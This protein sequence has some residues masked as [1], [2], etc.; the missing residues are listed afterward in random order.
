MTGVRSS[1]KLEAACRDQIPYL[2]LTGWQ[3]PDHNT[4][5]RFYQRHRQGMRELFKRTVRTAVALELVDL[6]VQAVDGTNVAANAAMDRTYSEEKLGRLLERVDKAIEDLEA[7][8]EGG[9]D[10]AT[11]RLPEQLA[12]RKGVAGASQ[13]GDGGAAWAAPSQSHQAAQAHQSDRAQA[14]R[15]RRM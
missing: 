4:L 9:E 7:Q 8:N 5:W 15:H 13:A 3:H 2:W 1:R 11:A 14:P 10:G 12:S 6:A